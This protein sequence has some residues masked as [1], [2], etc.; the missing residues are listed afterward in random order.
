MTQGQDRKI[1]G[2]IKRKITKRPKGRNKWKKERG[3]II[4]L[5]TKF[6]GKRA[7]ILIFK[8]GR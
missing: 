3:A 4:Y 8:S 5:P 1:I 6:V 7:T 2:I